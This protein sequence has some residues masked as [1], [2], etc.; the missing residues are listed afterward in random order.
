MLDI[1]EKEATEDFQRIV[2]VAPLKPSYKSA[3]VFSLYKKRIFWLC[4]LVVVSLFSSGL[5]AHFEDVLSAAIVLAF[6]IPLLIDSGGNMGS[7]SATLMIRA[8]ATEDVEINEWFRV[9]IREIGIGLLIGV[10][11]GFFPEL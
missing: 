11:L 4:L 9:F 7:Q 2:S 10:T 1:A 8:L 3:S 6:F 5:L